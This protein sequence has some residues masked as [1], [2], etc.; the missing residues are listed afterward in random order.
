MLSQS[1]FTEYRCEPLVQAYSTS[2]ASG[3]NMKITVGHAE[4]LSTNGLKI[5]LDDNNLC[6]S[7]EPQL[8]LVL[9]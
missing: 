9:V 8:P 3:P 4:Y 7:F 6:Q 2:V 1:T 5:T